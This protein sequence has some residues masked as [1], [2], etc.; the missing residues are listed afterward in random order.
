MPT[1]VWDIVL[2]HTL[3]PLL[4][5]WV[6]S[7]RLVC[8]ALCKLMDDHPYWAETLRTCIEAH[9]T[10]PEPCTDD[11][12]SRLA[13]WYMAH[14]LMAG[15]PH[16]V[17]TTAYLPHVRT[18]MMW[19][20]ACYADGR[21]L[22]STAS[23]AFF[24]GPRTGSN[25]SAVRLHDSWESFCA[26]GATEERYPH[27]CWLVKVADAK[28]DPAE[29]RP[30]DLAGERN[31]C[32]MCRDRMVAITESDIGRE[33]WEHACTISTR[34][35]SPRPTD[36]PARREGASTG[37]DGERSLRQGPRR[38]RGIRKAHRNGGTP[39]PVDDAHPAS[40]R[41]PTRWDVTALLRGRALRPVEVWVGC[42]RGESERAE[43]VHFMRHVPQPSV[44]VEKVPPFIAGNAR[45]VKRWVTRHALSFPTG[46]VYVHID[47]DRVACAYRLLPFVSPLAASKKSGAHERESVALPEDSKGPEDDVFLAGRVGDRFVRPLS[48]LVFACPEEGRKVDNFARDGIPDPTVAGRLIDRA[49]EDGA[50]A[51][52]EAVMDRLRWVEERLGV[53]GAESKEE[54]TERLL[55]AMGPKAAAFVR[56]VLADREREEEERG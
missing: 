25:V 14:R 2:A 9:V 31:R 40:P 34:S 56:S 4:Y 55:A 12:V 26:D 10:G 24:A 53:E 30:D 47:G 11:A 38:F 20:T 49:L 5:E 15:T 28:P 36:E 23:H 13:S 48:A 29:P 50:T 18:R 16:L 35:N 19:S 37:E 39:N 42:G 41:G 22:A 54:C 27:S 52:A 6:L 46:M 51:A 45:L 17:P 33:H 32:P 21:P 7:L 44:C 8:R 43:S 3:S 1:E